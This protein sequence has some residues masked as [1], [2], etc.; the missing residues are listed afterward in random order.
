MNIIPWLNEHGLSL[1]T[2]T[3]VVLVGVASLL[4]VTSVMVWAMG[5]IYR[6][7]RVVAQCRLAHLVESNKV[8]VVLTEREAKRR[9]QSD[10]AL[11]DKL[12]QL[13]DQLA[14]VRAKEEGLRKTEVDLRRLMSSQ[15]EVLGHR[16]QQIE[17][18]EKALQEQASMRAVVEEAHRVTVKERD[19][20][21]STLRSDLE[22]ERKGI[23]TLT[24]EFQCV[25]MAATMLDKQFKTQQQS[26][27]MANATVTDLNAKRDLLQEQ[28]RSAQAQLATVREVYGCP[29][30]SAI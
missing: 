24:T 16:A 28:L 21:I 9:A 26:L 15:A 13:S 29:T 2:C 18:L 27:E 19:A 25:Q 23:E 11:R 6:M 30:L 22:Q 17:V 12:Q 7:M 4:I 5:R 8:Q 20:T 1:L 3:G 14:E 10:G